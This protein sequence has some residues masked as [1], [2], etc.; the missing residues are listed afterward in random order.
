MWQTYVQTIES[1]SDRAES[2]NR[3]MIIVQ[4]AIFS[5]YFIVDNL[6]DLMS[7]IVGGVGAMIGFIWLGTIYR[8]MLT[9]RTKLKVIVDMEH[10]LPVRPITQES[11][12]M[13]KAVKSHAQDATFWNSGFSHVQML[14]VGV[15]TFIHLIAMSWFGWLS[16]LQVTYRTF[17]LSGQSNLTLLLSFSA[18]VVGIVG[19][20]LMRKFKHPALDSSW[21]L[22]G[23]VMAVAGCISAVTL[24]ALN[25]YGIL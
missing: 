15:V 6:P 17:G 18:S 16:V 12:M 20:G 14:I 24:T 5:G 2:I 13:K 23:L 21:F 4:V 9:Y 11:A 19:I 22:M 1:D 7:M 3:S 8:H 25:T 10:V